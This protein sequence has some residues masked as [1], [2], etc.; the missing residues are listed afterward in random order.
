MGTLPI[1][2]PSSSV[3]TTESPIPAVFLIQFLCNGGRMSC[4]ML[5]IKQK[6][7]RA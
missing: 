6:A 3:T 2:G 4:G 5:D 7:A 1:S